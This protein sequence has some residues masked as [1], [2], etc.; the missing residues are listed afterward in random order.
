M[1]T[2]LAPLPRTITELETDRPNYERMR[3]GY[4][5]KLA[6]GSHS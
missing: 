6:A 4:L 2:E 3:D 1:N 5:R